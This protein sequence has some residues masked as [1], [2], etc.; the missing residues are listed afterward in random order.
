MGTLVRDRG[1]GAVNAVALIDLI[2][3][4]SGYRT[5]IKALLTWDEGGARRENHHF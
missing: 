3:L 2:H 4:T 1:T 5:Q